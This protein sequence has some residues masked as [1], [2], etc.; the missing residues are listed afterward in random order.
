[1]MG[2]IGFGMMFAGRVRSPTDNTSLGN[3]QGQL[4]L[5]SL[6]ELAQLHAMNLGADERSDVVYLGL[7]LGEQIWECGIGVLAMI[8]VLEG[9]Q[10]RI[11]IEIQSVIVN[12]RL[13]QYGLN[14]LAVSLSQTG[15]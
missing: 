3:V 7:A 2:S 10:R 14:Y 15:K 12:H 6:G 5:A 13:G 1:M 4:V 9:F 11:S 8:I